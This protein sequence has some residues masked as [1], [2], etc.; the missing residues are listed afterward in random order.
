MKIRPARIRFLEGGVPF[1]EEFDDVYF[2]PEGGLQETEYVFLDGNDLPARW[3]GNSPF[4][5]AELGFG[6]GLNFLTTL[7]HWVESRRGE[8]KGAGHL[9]FY[10]CELFPVSPDGHAQALRFFPELAPYSQALLARFPQFVYGLHCIDF[11]E[12]QATLHLFLGPVEQYLKTVPFRADAWF[13]DGFAPSK[14]EAM[15]GEAIGKAIAHR[16]A[17]GATCATFS[18][19]APAKQVLR[20]A[21][22]ELK[23]RKGFGRKREMLQGVRIGAI[24]SSEEGTDIKERMIPAPHPV[25]NRNKSQTRVAVVGAGLAGC[26]VAHELARRGFHVVLFDQRDAPLQ[27]AS[28]NPAGIFMPYLSAG[29]SETSGFALQSLSYL[30]SIFEELRALPGFIGA[31][32]GV[33]EVLTSPEDEARVRRALERLG[34]G[35]SYTRFLDPQ[36]TQSL[37]GF[38]PEKA[39]IFHAGAGWLKPASL[40]RALLQ[41]HP[42][43][44]QLRL[45]T[46]VSKFAKNTFGMWELEGEAFDA[47]VVAC[48]NQA[49]GFPHTSFLPL[50]PLRGQIA[51]FPQSDIGSGFLKLPVVAQEYFCPTEGDLAVL[52]ATFDLKEDSV[53]LDPDKNRSLIPRIQADLGPQA[54]RT[55]ERFDPSQG[56]VAFRCTTADKLPVVGPVPDAGFYQEN[57]AAFFRGKAKAGAVFPEPRVHE[58]LYV[59]TGF[60]SRG[61]TYIPWAARILAAEMLGEPPVVQDDIRHKLSPARFLIRALRKGEK[62]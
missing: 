37:L 16:S 20:A 12:W 62:R 9:H 7:K 45:G 18:V 39:A 24:A 17:P 22:F 46:V 21:G 8:R 56:R 6:T 28:G 25:Q 31:R 3:Q 51:A 23:K 5:I 61:I 13:L 50:T 49:M 48:A 54:F 36:A 2:S 34:L 10:S 27:E 41:L 55:L 42:E 43:K 19:A 47:V 38:L 52:G 58:G 4:T 60:G 14:N 40:G 32:T 44:I 59:M 26:F 30:N 1:S 33:A 35:E 11:P 57:Y 15:W 29:E 53:Q